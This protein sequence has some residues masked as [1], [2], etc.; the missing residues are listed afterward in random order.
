MSDRIA[1]MHTGRIVQIGT[2]HQIYHQPCNAF[3]AT[4]VGAH[5]MLMGC[6]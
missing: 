2:P 1:V 4:F 3:V 6:S 5:R